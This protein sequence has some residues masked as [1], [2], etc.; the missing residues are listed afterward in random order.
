VIDRTNLPPKAIDDQPRQTDPNR[1]M[2]R[3]RCKLRHDSR[4]NIATPVFGHGS[5]VTGTEA[6]RKRARWPRL[7]RARYRAAM[8]RILPRERRVCYNCGSATT[9]YHVE[10]LEHMALV[11]L[12]KDMVELRNKTRQAMV[13][14]LTDALNSS[15]HRLETHSETELTPLLELL[16]LV[17]D[18]Q[19]SR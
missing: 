6:F 18:G 8:S 4:Q 1:L 2:P 5:S 17:K 11:C 13:R 15:V 16:F 12:H 10:T 14:L 9:G 7:D 3:P 19:T